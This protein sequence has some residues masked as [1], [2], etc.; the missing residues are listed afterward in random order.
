M[1]NGGMGNQMFQYA[2]ARRLQVEYGMDIVCD[3]AKFN[4]RN[5]NATKRKYC[6]DKF[7]L[8]KQ[9]TYRKTIFAR[10]YYKIVKN[11]ISRK[12]VSCAEEYKKLTQ[13]GVFAP[14]GYFE[15]YQEEKAHSRNLYVNGLFQSH[16]YFD[17]ILPILRKE[18]TICTPPRVEIEK[19]ITRILNEESVCVHWR[20][21]DYLSERYKDTL[22][23]CNEDY[24]D[25]AIKKIL[26]KV[27]NPILYIFTNSNEDAE[28]IKSNHKFN[29]P[30]N[31][32]NLMIQEQH[33]DLED[34][35]IMCACKH[36]IIS[37]STFSWWAQYLSANSSKVVV[38]PDTWNRKADAS[39]LYFDD[40]E[41]IPV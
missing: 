12:G 17:S 20:R 24:Y 37:N 22:L 40:W 23:V 11:S 35:R 32:I 7:N 38:A 9:L 8:S 33:S 34:F 2:V 29:V 25:R 15:F 16:Q 21:G 6:L 41:V 30:V 10:V 13:K 5:S 3:L 27:K 26:E 1:N 14:K 4:Y 39:G 31:Y 19:I 36:F 28:W 18:F